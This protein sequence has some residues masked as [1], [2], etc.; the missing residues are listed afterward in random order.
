[1]RY[2]LGHLTKYPNRGKIDYSF[3]KP[4][5]IHSVTNTKI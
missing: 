5:S 1:M 4:P 3:F 2:A